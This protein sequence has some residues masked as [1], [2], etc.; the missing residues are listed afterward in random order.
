[1]AGGGGGGGGGGGWLRIIIMATK[2]R[3]DSIWQA[4]S[5][6]VVSPGF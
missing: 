6:K 3:R 2:M 1:M 4:V 5:A